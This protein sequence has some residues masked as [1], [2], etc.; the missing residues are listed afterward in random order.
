MDP[1]PSF[2]RNAALVISFPT[3][4]DQD[5]DK[6]EGNIRVSSSSSSSSAI[7]VIRVACSMISSRRDAPHAVTN[8]TM[9]THNTIGGHHHHHRV[10]QKC[11][12]K[13]GYMYE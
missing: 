4:E 3:E 5:E 7:H 11:F 10:F 8:T 2:K 1:P 13:I 12:P 9:S 6:E